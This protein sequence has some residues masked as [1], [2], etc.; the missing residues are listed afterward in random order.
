MCTEAVRVGQM[1]YCLCKSRA[2][3][4]E[5]KTDS[6]LYRLSRNR[7]VLDPMSLEDAARV[8]EVF[9]GRNQRRNNQYYTP[10]AS[11]TSKDK[12]FRVQDAV[13]SDLMAD[14]D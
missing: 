10:T 5:I 2:P 9:E 14:G 6:V 4:Y 11:C 1:L 7:D 3:I 12:I 13:E 8:R